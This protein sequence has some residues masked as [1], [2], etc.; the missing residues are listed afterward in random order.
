MIKKYSLALLW[1]LTSVVTAESLWAQQRYTDE[2]FSNSQITTLNNVPYGY[3]FS[4]YVPANLGGPMVVPMYA[5]IYM[6]DTVA[7]PVASRP[8][9]ILFHTGSF[10]PRGL[11]SPMGD[12]KD[13]AV[14]EIAKRFARRGFIAVSATYRLGWLANST[15][16]DLRRGTNLMAVY[17]A[18]QDAKVC[19]R[20]VR[21]SKLVQGDP[22]RVDPNA[23]S[24]I[25]VGS[26]GYVTLAYATI[27]NLAE[28]ASPAKFKYTTAGTGIFGNAVTAGMPYVDTARVGDWNGYGGKAT[29]IGAHPVTGLPLVD[30]TQPGRN[31]E[32]YKG[33]PS[34]VNFVAN[35]GGALGD[36]A[37]MAQGDAA[38]I[39][40][41]SRFD[42][43][44]PYYRGM[45][46]VP[47]A[48]SFFPV[49]D[50]AGSHTAVKMA[51]TFG[52]NSVFNA[53]SM[54]DPLSVKARN[55]PYNVGNQEN[56]Y[57]F[58]MLPP[59]AAMPFKVNANPWDW[60][61][62]ADPLSANET[63]PNVKA[64]SKLYID[65]VMGFILPRMAKALNAVGYNVG[66]QEQATA[67]FQ[68]I[69][70]PANNFARLRLDGMHAH[71]GQV[72][73]GLGRLFMDQTVGIEDELVLNTS[74]WKSGI[75][76]VR[77]QTDLG[78][79]TKQLMKS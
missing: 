60:W 67:S 75:Y 14:V 11:A 16:L 36:S 59:N 15:N 71:N 3:N 33:I 22:Y 5:D 20:A 51:N 61:N 65:T 13:S 63:N 19:V 4:Q 26:G 74:A 1:A 9:V 54:M 37:W 12:R 46:N 47:I 57:T 2:V 44:A 38:V 31:I 32:L 70:N 55:N 48:G 18:V 72:L 6:P 66:V 34:N 78:V 39:S 30:Q 58:N 29:I 7:D 52:N 56:L 23:I 77:V 73:D 49:V 69:P 21:A 8:V 25:G 79:Q 40:L 53:G 76:W 43:F 50:V 28:V 68:I 42:F 64:Q 10:L 17:N 24:L 27:N 45:V 41:H 35:L 62:P